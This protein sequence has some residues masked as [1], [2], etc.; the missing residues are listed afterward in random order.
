M[1]GEHK[2][3]NGG[4]GLDPLKP[5]PPQLTDWYRAVPDNDWQNDCWN[6]VESH[7]PIDAVRV[8]QISML[9]WVTNRH[10]PG[11]VMNFMEI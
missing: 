4:G 1:T 7:P 11:R 9:D 3:P 2:Q 5:P 8:N 10:I 6:C